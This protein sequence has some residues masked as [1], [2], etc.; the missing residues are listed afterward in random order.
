VDLVELDGAQDQV[1]SLIFHPNMYAL[2][3]DK[4]R[5]ALASVRTMPRE[6]AIQ[7]LKTTLV[8]R[9][10]MLSKMHDIK[11]RDVVL[12]GIFCV[13]DATTI[14]CGLSKG[15][16]LSMHDEAQMNSEVIDGFI[17]S[18]QQ[19]HAVS[20]NTP[21]PTFVPAKLMPSKSGDSVPALD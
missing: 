10:G 16:L 9:D 5:D 13:S 6:Q 2:A 17:A 4:I 15:A 18:V 20:A 1:G 21:R 19:E 3:I 11:D 7:L 8:S 12:E 14:P